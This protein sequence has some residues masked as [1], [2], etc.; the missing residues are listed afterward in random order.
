MEY[1]GRR[2]FAVVIAAAALSCDDAERVEDRD[3]EEAFSSEADVNGESEAVYE[4]ND[5]LRRQQLEGSTPPLVEVTTAKGNYVA[6][7]VD[8]RGDSAR[9]EWIPEGGR[10]VLNDSGAKTPAA[11]FRE[12]VPEGKMPEAIASANPFLPE[13]PTDSL[14]ADEPAPTADDRE[15]ALKSR[16]PEPEA[17]NAAACDR[18]QQNYFYDDYRPGMTADESDPGFNYYGES[19][20][21]DRGEPV[22]TIVRAKY[23]ADFF[24]TGYPQWTPIRGTRM[25]GIWGYLRTSVRACDTNGMRLTAWKCYISPLTTGDYG[26]GH[27]NS[28]VHTQYGPY[29]FSE[30]VAQYTITGHPGDYVLRSRLDNMTNGTDVAIWTYFN[31]TYYSN[32]E[33]AVDEDACFY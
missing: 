10:S 2:V 6:I 16:E 21:N 3:A 14:A 11:L 29:S 33:G 30:G 20:M 27:A 28:D 32:G 25:G 9:F 12:L 26:C 15:L 18:A 4:I 22:R 7:W 13:R 24:Q 19:S 8:E 5:V 23:L 1:S 17:L 31:G